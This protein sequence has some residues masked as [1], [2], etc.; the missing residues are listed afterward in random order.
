MQ[1]VISRSRPKRPF[2]LAV[3]TTTAC[4][5]VA[6]H[7]TAWISHHDQTVCQINI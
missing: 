4:W 3:N 2:R 1:A 5:G 7:C 6:K